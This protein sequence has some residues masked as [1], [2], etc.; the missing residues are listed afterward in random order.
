MATID[1]A[2]N[3]ALLSVVEKLTEQNN[4]LSNGSVTIKGDDGFSPTV[5]TSKVGNT[6]RITFTNKDDENT[7]L[8]NDGQDGKS[9]YQY[10]K[11]N[12]YNGTET[13]YAT[14]MNP[15]NIKAAVSAGLSQIEVPTVVSSVDEM[16]DTTKHYVDKNTGMIWAY[17]KNII[18][19][20]GET[21]PNFENVF[22]A[23][24]AELNCRWS[25]SAGSTT[26]YSGNIV[27]YFIPCDLSSGEHTL[28]IKNGY[29][30]FSSNTNTSISYFTGED[31]GSFI[32]MT[33]Y[34]RLTVT[35]EADG[36]YAYKLGYKDGSLFS[37]YN[38]TRYIRVTFRATTDGIDI[39]PATLSAARNVIIT[40]DQPITYTETPPTTEVSNEW[41]D[42][43]IAYAPTFRTDLVGV[44]GEN[45]VIY[46]S[47]NLPSGTYTLKYP[48][49]DYTIIGTISK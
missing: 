32:D 40:I 13:D 2:S 30:H 38:K 36:V 21:T 31:N 25:G 1:V 16:T 10:A 3:S 44:L 23:E 34:N 14:D 42:T 28:R 45:N 46:L 24:K 27:S 4:I 22:D 41:T 35:E 11:D 48:D 49:N 47:D 17:M 18:Y 7:I 33:A 19:H 5:T 8:I 26:S 37:N 43:G 39:T 12:G 9:S 15:D 20:E 6:A 29:I